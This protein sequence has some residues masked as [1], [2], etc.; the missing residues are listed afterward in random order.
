M[1]EQRTTRQATSGIASS[2]TVVTTRVSAGEIRYLSCAGRLAVLATK[3]PPPKLMGWMVE[4]DDEENA[5]HT[6]NPPNRACSTETREQA[7]P[8]S[9]TRSD[10]AATALPTD[11]SVASLTAAW[12]ELQHSESTVQLPKSRVEQKLAAGQRLSRD[13]RKARKRLLER[14]LKQSRMAG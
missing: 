11:T 4:A 8:A 10:A 12:N 1:G 9:K 6:T 2:G 5:A 7:P 13:D 3:L 14:K